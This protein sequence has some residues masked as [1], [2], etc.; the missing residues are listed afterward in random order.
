M[1]KLKKVLTPFVALMLAM[2]M[3]FAVACGNG[4]QGDNGNDSGNNNTQ[5]GDD[6]Q[7]GGN[8]DGGNTDNQTYYTVT[9]VVDGED[10]D[11]QQI[12][13]GSTVTPPS[14]P[15]KDGEMFMGWFE[16][17]AST[18]P[19]DFTQPITSAKTFVAKYAMLDAEFKAV[20]AY[21]ES[22]YVEWEETNP[23]MA[24][25]EYVLEGENNWT[26]VDA[27]LIRAISS[28]EAR[29]DIVGLAAN[30]YNVR[31]TLSSG[32]VVQLPAP[33]QVTA[34][35]RSGYAH[36]NYTD[37]VGAYNDDGSLK[38][39]ALVIYVTEE[40]KNDVTDS[41]YVN[42]Q[43]VDI[44]KYLVAN[45]A[46]EGVTVGQQTG[47][48]EL[49]NNRRYSGNDRMNVGIAKL[50][51]V[52]GAVAIRIV[53]TV[54]AEIAGTMNS[55]IN[56]LT[57]YD[58]TGNGGSIGDNGRMARIVNAHDLTIEG[59]GEASIYGWGVHFI[60]SESSGKTA[61]MG[62]SFEV[63]N[64]TFENYPEDAIG[65]EGEQASKKST[66]LISSPVE[67]C[68]IHN[69]TFL[70]GYASSPAESDKGEGDGSCDFKRGM[71]YTNS[72]NYYES[73]HKTNLVGSASYSLQFNITFHHNWW[74][75]C[76]SRQPL[77][78]H[79]NIHFYNNYI[80]GT[81]DTV[82]SM[83]AM[84]YMYSEANYYNTCT[85]PVEYK[86]EDGGT[87]IV[88]SF[89]DVF[90]NCTKDNSSAKVETRDQYV[91]NNCTYSAANINY[92]HFDTDPNLFYYDA[93]N[94]VSDCFL[95]TAIEAR[96]TVIETAGANGQGI[97]PAPGLNDYTPTSA[98]TI[99]PNGDTVI[100][101]PT[102]KND[103]EVNGVLFRGLTGASSGTIKFK[104]QGITFTLAAEA[105]ITVTG[106]A[107]AAE[108]CPELVRTDGTVMAAKFN[109]TIRLVLPA[110]TYFITSG[111]GLL[112]GKNAKESTISELKFADTSESSAARVQAAIDAINAIPA[113]AELTDAYAQLISSARTA[114]NALTEAEKAAF[115]ATIYAKLEAAEAAYGELLIAQF[116]SLVAA[117]GTVT[118]DSY[119]AINAAQSAYD[120]LTNAQKAQVTAEKA[121]LDGAWAAFEEYE[122]TNVIDMIDTFVAKVNN[123]NESSDRATIEALIDESETIQAAYTKLSDDGEDGPSQQAQVTNYAKLTEAIA[124]LESLNNI[125]IFRDAL[126]YFEN[127][128]VT[129]ADAAQVSELQ[130]LYNALTATQKTALTQTE[131]ALYDSVIADFA[132]LQQALITCSFEGG[133]ASNSMFTL[134]SKHNPR[135]ESFTA[136]DGT[137]LT[138]A[139]KMESGTSISFATSTAKTLTLYFTT[140]SVGNKIKIDGTSYTVE[141][142]GGYAIVTVTIEAGSHIIEKDSTNVDLFYLTLA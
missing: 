11:V 123:A 92:S 44:A 136:P 98:V 30:S 55:S 29:V 114:Y 117:I 8:Q 57:D 41:A 122:V 17:I 43:K 86:S 97:S 27:P 107:S 80:S 126:E 111:V 124:K 71:Y 112:A 83:R 40:N 74:N 72:Y 119:D 75:N 141:S 96:K 127:H 140:R 3:L 16:S 64:L 35:D 9:F 14:A 69:N 15:I 62:K 138:S 134:G 53:G 130:G 13:S 63:R 38:N 93:E 32:D 84:S 100:N 33:V 5:G 25:V 94:K 61:R 66:A 47:I 60:S 85:R 142:S 110:G 139:M 48:G 73:C 103:T 50:S 18:T 99:N 7:G 19:Y 59:V 101:L 31:I 129:M 109:G 4:A 76:Q 87:G 120:K 46:A 91:D 36:F 135:N 34:Y 51:E 118:K 28:T 90:L 77:A 42:G 10:Y 58:T 102:A 23:E 68:W 52:Y 39:G 20:G 2:V 104:G 131:K 21:N 6:N 56:G 79:A 115:D 45:T 70:P 121:T 37:G 1:T 128:T 137:T 106:T 65:M 24:I 81:T 78:R 26:K 82:S 88:K 22:L 95:Q 113:T 108:Y 132:A 125:Y 133:V 54:S 67:R 89:N 116:K 49:L 105:E 12:Q